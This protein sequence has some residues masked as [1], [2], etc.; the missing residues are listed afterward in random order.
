M[1]SPAEDSYLLSGVIAKI[2]PEMLRKNSEL[3][4]L[5]IGCGSGILLETAYEAGVKRKNIFGCD[6]DSESVSHCKSL[7]F[8]CVNSDMFK[9]IKGKFDLIVFNPPYLP[10]EKLDKG[11]DTSSGKKG[12]KAAISFLR[13]FGKHLNQKGKALFLLSS[14]TS[15]ERI[16]K[17]L[18]R[19]SW[20]EAVRKKLFFEEIY[21]LEFS[22]KTSR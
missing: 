19:F 11:I 9:S 12:D 4:F 1:Y 13:N 17:W 16:N 7:G 22:S 6:V 20:R 2:I 3:K 10:E 8:R 14:L 15:M 5:E 21:V 18:P